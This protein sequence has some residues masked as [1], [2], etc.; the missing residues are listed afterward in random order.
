MFVRRLDPSVLTFS[1]SLY[2]YNKQKT[3][4]TLFNF[5][6]FYTSSF[7]TPI[8]DEYVNIL[9][10]MYNTRFN[11]SLLN[12]DIT[13]VSGRYRYPEYRGI[14]GDVPLYPEKETVVYPWGY[15]FQWGKSCESP[16]VPEIK[17]VLEAIRTGNILQNIRT[18]SVRK[19]R[20]CLRK[21]GRLFS[22]EENV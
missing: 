19:G 1:L 20:K 15:R 8:D 12:H 22:V 7:I 21:W 3:L 6:R 16:Q 11:R 9:R 18:T 2:S 13:P 17:C 14:S 10:G 5:S 4:C